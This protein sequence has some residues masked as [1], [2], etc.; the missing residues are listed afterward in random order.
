VGSPAYMAPEQWERTATGPPSDWYAVGVMLFEAL[1]GS[2]PFA[3]S[4]EEVVLRKRTVSAPRASQL[5][6]AVPPDLDDWTARLLR[7]DPSQRQPAA[8]LR[9]AFPE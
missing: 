3:G 9:E 5:V 6:A 2:L 7:T 8:A 1:T 4:G